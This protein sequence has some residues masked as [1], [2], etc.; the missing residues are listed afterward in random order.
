TERRRTDEF[1]VFCVWLVYRL[2]GRR[3]WRACKSNALG[4]AAVPRTFEPSTVST[5]GRHMP[6]R[7]DTD[8]EKRVWP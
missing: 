5:V 8:D 6:P 7:P 1:S 3:L 2:R 4:P